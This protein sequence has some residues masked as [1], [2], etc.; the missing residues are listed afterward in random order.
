MRIN[1]RPEIDGLRAIAVFFVILFHANL[2]FLGKNIFTGGFL[3]VDIF[4]VISG[5]LITSIILKEVFTKQTFSFKYFY[6]RRIRR[7]F[8]VL[9]FIIFI[10][11]IVSYF[12]FLDDNFID[13]LKSEISSIF[14]LSNFY[15]HYSGNF[16]G[17]ENSLIKPLTHTWSLS[18][19]EQFY[20]FFPIALL[21]ILKFFRKYIFLILFLV[22]L[23]SLSLAQ[24]CSKTH[25]S[26]NFYLLPTR[27][28]ELLSGTLFAYFKLRKNIMGGGGKN[29]F[30]FL[31]NFNEI[32][33]IIGISLIFYSFIFFDNNQSSYPSLFTLIPIT[34]TGIIIIF[35][36]KNLI[37]KILSNKIFVFFGLISYSLYLWHFPIFAFLRYAGLFDESIKIKILS[38]LLCII[39][40]TISYSIIEKPCRNERSISFKNLVV[41]LSLSV[42]IILIFSFY[43]LKNNRPKSIFHKNIITTQKSYHD[44]IKYNRNS[45][46]GNI[47]LIGDSHAGSLAYYLNENLKSINYNLYF[48]QSDFFIHDLELINR[49]IKNNSIKPILIIS[50]RWVDKINSIKNLNK[51]LQEIIISSINNL[52]K[53]SYAIIIIYPVPEYNFNPS[54]VI[55]SR[56]IFHK[57]FGKNNFE[58]PIL[59]I[60]YSEYK[61]KSQNVFNILNNIKGDNVYKVYPHKHFCATEIKDK[62]IT[63]NKSNIFYYDNN[64]LSR[65]GSKYIVKDIINII[66]TNK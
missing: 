61:K 56:Y 62:C 40:S 31:L 18:I 15:F 5:Y 39:L 13:F 44:K 12:L 60:N 45:N 7:I 30:K 23:I 29:S 6:E 47:I 43:Y 2:S 48:H 21:I 3:G 32:I 25:Q 64:H 34:G 37:K 14:F 27:I 53:N 66:K 46:L 49:E 54:A 22:F 11:S 55:Q 41:C 1:Y 50:H 59:S 24:Y 51:N 4:F 63:N 10:C 20:I 17:N 8:P 35:S 52:V 16:Y 9:F 42:I 28:F 38:I 36:K 65:E 26:F 33:A 57:I 19:E 58:L